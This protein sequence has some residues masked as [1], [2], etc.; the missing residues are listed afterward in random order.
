M[1]HHDY[2]QGYT[3]KKVCGLSYLVIDPKY[4]L[5]S[6]DIS[7]VE[8]INSIPS[9]YNE[10]VSSY[11]Q[12]ISLLLAVFL[13]YLGWAI[14]GSFLNPPFLVAAV[15]GILYVWL[16]ASYTNKQRR[17][18]LALEVVFFDTDF[19]KRFKSGENPEL[20]IPLEAKN[21]KNVID[22]IE[23]YHR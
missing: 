23:F 6:K 10:P 16:Y 13:F 20:I 18:R 2:G 7:P 21:K 14:G 3:E 19:L 15:V 8:A 17:L 1:K 4:F 12:I 9:P 5:A 11:R 22:M